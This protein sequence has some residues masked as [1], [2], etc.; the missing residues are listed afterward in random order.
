ML[1]T[2]DFFDLADFRHQAVFDQGPV[3]NA[4]KGLKSYMDSLN[5][6]AWNRE[7]PLDQPLPATLVIIDGKIIPAKGLTLDLGDA[8]K[9]K[10]TISKDGQI[11][12]GASVLMAGAILSG[13]KISLGR[14]VF[15]EAGALIKSPAVIDDYTEIRQGAYLRGYCLIG[16]RCVVGHVTEVKHSIFLNDAKAG[17]FAYLGDSILGNHVNLG[18][19]TKLANLRFTGGEVPVKTPNG[20]MATGLRKFGAIMADNVQTGCNSVT[21]PGAL[22][23]KRSMLLPNT[24]SPSGYHPPN[25][26][27]KP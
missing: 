22:L 10:M 24:T 7:I 23:G 16:K 6:P 1:T 12:A 20:T 21:N 15:V 25:S 8:T 26:I 5:Y 18:A 17:H 19:G 27:I 9:G 3:W 13:E 2:V 11:L 14:G 4:L